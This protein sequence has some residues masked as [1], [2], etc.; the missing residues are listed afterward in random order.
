MDDRRAGKDEGIGRREP[1]DGQLSILLLTRSLDVG[2][3]Q[4]Q[5]VELAIGL[6]ERGHLVK[7]AVF[8]GGAPL[9]KTVESAGVPVVDLHKSGRW[10]VARFLGR[11]ISLVRRLHP[12]VIYSILGDANIVAALVKPF[13]PRAALVWSVRNSAFDKSVN[14]WLSKAGFKG[15]AALSRSPDAIIANSSAGR[16][17]A[18][19]RG[20]PADKMKVIPNGIDTDRFRPDALLRRQQRE[21]LGLRDDEI[22]VGVL[23][24]LN[25]TKD[26]PTFLRAAARVAEAIPNAKFLCVGGGPELERLQ[27]LVRELGIWERVIFAG[28][29]D[30]PSALNAFDIACS[31]SATEGFSNAI[32]E[33][34]AC[35]LPCVVTD[36]GDS[37]AIVG[38]TGT[39]VSAGSPDAL[40]EAILATA[41]AL[42]RHDPARSRGRILESFSPAAMV[43]RTI[44]VFREVRKGPR[45]AGGRN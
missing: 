11:A 1:P 38:D 9:V 8:Y 30:A 44:A 4:Q 15:E 23:A 24:R 36:V 18:I 5:L 14:H 27:Q 20:F 12:D 26:Y 28:E 37:A 10:D 42:D 33:A 39:V 40:A 35:G 43:D 17:F 13:A 41:A 16:D 25:S 3:A 34:M 45:N 31:P 22:A 6:R 2:G 29:I 19:S 21:E 7:V 32:A